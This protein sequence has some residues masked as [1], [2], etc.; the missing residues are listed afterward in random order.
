[1]IYSITGVAVT[2]GAIKKDD[3]NR[4]QPRPIPQPPAPTDNQIKGGK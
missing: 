2:H 3:R 4:P 1:M